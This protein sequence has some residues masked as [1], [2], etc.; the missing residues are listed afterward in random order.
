MIGYSHLLPP[1]GGETEESSANAALR[2]LKKKTRKFF[3]KKIS[4]G[5]ACFPPRSFFHEW[6]AG[7]SG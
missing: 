1:T 6:T 3:P 7:R 2:D 5:N 4:A